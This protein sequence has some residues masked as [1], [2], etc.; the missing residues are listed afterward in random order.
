MERTERMGIRGVDGSFILVNKW[1]RYIVMLVIKV[2]YPSG[3]LERVIKFD[4]L[5]VLLIE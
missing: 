3:V 2:T 1:S 5:Q 4:I